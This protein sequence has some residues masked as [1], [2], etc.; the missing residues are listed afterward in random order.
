MWTCLQFVPTHGGQKPKSP[1]VVFCGKHEYEKTNFYQCPRA[2]DIIPEKKF[3]RRPKTDIRILSYP[4]LFA[5]DAKYHRVCYS[6]Y[7]SE[8]NIA[9]ARRK[10]GEAAE[11]NV[12]DEAF[13]ELKTHLNQ[14]VFSKQKTVMTLARLTD[15]FQIFFFE[16]GA[17][18][19]QQY[20]AWKLKERLRKH[21]GDQLVIVTFDSSTDII[22][23]S[24]VT[25]S[26][27][28]R[29]ASALQNTD[30]ETEYKDIVDA[31]PPTP[32]EE[33]QILHTAFGILRKHMAGITCSTDMYAPVADTNIQKCAKFVPDPMYDFVQWCLNDKAYN[34]LASCSS[35]DVPKNKRK[36]IAICHN[37]I[38]LNKVCSQQ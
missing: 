15:Q 10:S 8:L 30:E 22:C 18:N 12:Y 14:T 28:L 9:S 38:S 19:A 1:D 31:V 5:Y 16:L 7:I 20:T 34:N 27:A 17:S 11:T 32:L 25:L 29:K 4:D 35:E 6:H 23:S 2:P 3:S 26:D 36:V 37:M 13:D 21:F 33:M 24:A